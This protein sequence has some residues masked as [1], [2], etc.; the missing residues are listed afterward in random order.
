MEHYIGLGFFALCIGIAV[1]L[2]I[3]IASITGYYV[4]IGRKK[5]EVSSQQET[6]KKPT[7]E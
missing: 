2:V 1:S 3:C 5:L 4:H 6:S 7:L